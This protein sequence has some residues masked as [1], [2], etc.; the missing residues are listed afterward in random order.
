M[1]TPRS[2]AEQFKEIEKRRAAKFLADK[3]AKQ[4]RWEKRAYPY[5]DFSKKPGRY[6][7]HKTK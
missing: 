7:L 6:G 4:E 1:S 2:I 3:R 5:R